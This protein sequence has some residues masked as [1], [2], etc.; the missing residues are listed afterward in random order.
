[1][2]VLTTNA[3]VTIRS[4]AVGG[5]GIR[6]YHGDLLTRS[7]P[8]LMDAY[9]TLFER[10]APTI[11]A[12]PERVEYEKSDLLTPQLRLHADAQVEIYYAP[13]GHVNELARVMLIG[14]TPGFSQ[15][16]IAFQVAHAGL[17]A[18]LAVREI[19]QRITQ[20]AALAGSMRRNLVT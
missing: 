15:T 1:M 9:V 11:A 4:R 13:F 10:F 7:E 16:Q 2:G 5:R 8:M 14:I 17:Q 18:G 20:A 3:P 19:F 12:L 6:Y